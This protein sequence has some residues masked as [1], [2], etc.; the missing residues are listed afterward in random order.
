MRTV[1]LYMTMTCDGC[2]A[3]PGG[4]LDWMAAVTDPEMNRD[5]VDLISEADTAFMGYPTASG[6]IPYW[7]QSAGNPAASEGEHAIADAVNRVRSLVLSRTRE[8]VPWDNAELLIVRDDNDLRE[9]VNAAKHEPGRDIG[10]P[11]GIRTAQAFARLDLIDEY[12]LMMHPVALGDGQR[13]FSRRTDLDLRSAKTYRSG[14]TRL[15]YKPR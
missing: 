9:A 15:I 12:V 3:G 2:L 11:G 4:E 14:V 1:R 13:M 6:M 5:V 10:V 8:E 7:R